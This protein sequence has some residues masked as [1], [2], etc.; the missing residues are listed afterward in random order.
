MTSIFEFTGQSKLDRTRYKGTGVNLINGELWLIN[1]DKPLCPIEDTSLRIRR[2]L[3]CEKYENPITTL[4]DLS[5]LQNALMGTAISFC[6]E[7]G[8][9]DIDRL[10]F[11]VD[12]IQDSVEYGEWTPSTDSSLMAHG[13]EDDRQKLIGEV[14]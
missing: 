8:L 10:S 5:D 14:M 4:K 11:G 9:T 1:G 7:R 3:K 2:D 12:G 6:K 13:Y